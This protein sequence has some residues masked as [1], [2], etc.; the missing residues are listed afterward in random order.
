MRLI[1]FLS[2]IT[3]ICNIAFLLFAFFRWNELKRS[4]NAGGDN[5]VHVP[6]FKELIII[7]GVCAI[8]INL[9]MAIIYLIML[10]RGKIKHIPLWLLVVNFIFLILQILYFFFY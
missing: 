6:L 3:L 9:L 7:L 10:V 1:I 5:L 4:A 2:R 8:I